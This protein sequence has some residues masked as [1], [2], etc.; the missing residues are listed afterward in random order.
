VKVG[1]RGTFR[2]R[3]F[4]GRLFRFLQPTQ[5]NTID[6][7]Q[8]PN[9][10]LGLENI[11][12][13]RFVI[14]ES[15][16]GTDTYDATMDTHGA[17]AMADIALGSRWRISGGVRFEDSNA[18]V[19]T[20]DPL[21]PG[22]IPA[23]ARLEN[24]DV[25]P[26]VNVIYSLTASHN[27]RFGYGRTLSRPDFRELSP[28]EFTNVL[29]G[30]NTVGNPDLKR[31][32]IDNFDG[33]WEWFLGGDQLIAISYFRKDFTDPI[34]VTVQ[35]TTDLRQSFVNAKKAVNQGAELEWRQNLR[36]LHDSLIHFSVKANF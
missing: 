21:V 7:R 32:Q 5:V 31:A 19:R 23:V 34:E 22:A 30:F 13:D 3:D 8:P 10:L 36:F 1:Y 29:G 17:F 27:L 25:L 6:F 9:T 28:F 11:R 24:K 2:E 4:E 15:T 20:I 35:P 33:R 12:P 26:A 16:R 14:T 18:V